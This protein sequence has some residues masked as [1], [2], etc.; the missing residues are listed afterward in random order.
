M[1]VFGLFVLWL[2]VKLITLD[3]ENKLVVPC[4]AGSLRNS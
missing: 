2:V 1:M 3:D 4:P